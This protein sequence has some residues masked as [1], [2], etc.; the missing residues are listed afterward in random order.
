MRIVTHARD[1]HLNVWKLPSLTETGLEVILPIDIAASGTA[2]EAVRKPWLV[3]SL[4]VNTLNFCGFGE[5]IMPDLEDSGGQ[6][7]GKGDDESEVGAGEGG[8]AQWGQQMLLAVPSAADSE[9]VDI[10]RI[11]DGARMWRSIKPP[12]SITSSIGSASANPERKTGM[13]M[14]LHLQYFRMDEQAEYLL[15]AAGYESGE[16]LIYRH[17]LEKNL[18]GKPV[19]SSGESWEV[20]YA[21]RPHSQPVLSLCAAVDDAVFKVFTSSADSIISRYEYPLSRLNTASNTKSSSSFEPESTLVDTRH[22]GQQSITMRS[23]QKLLATAGWDGRVRV[24]SSKKKMK[25]LAV[26]KWHSVGCYAVT[27]ASVLGMNTG[28]P[29]GVQVREG[30]QSTAT[31]VPIAH[32]LGG[33]NSS[34]ELVRR[35][36]GQ[37][38]QLTE[39]RLSREAQR[40]FREAARHWVAAGDK[41][42]KVSLWDVY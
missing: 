36:S 40:E 37:Q 15:L 24:Y 14:C 26:L 30:A 25:E 39:Q 22:L 16:L 32:D 17:R 42:G 8:F 11:P 29:V 33:G 3:A 10:M 41:D 35:D 28:K 9:A 7:H 1:H 4:L 18:S 19:Q 13:A 12:I 34:T 6:Q 21:A 31:V 5:C 2:A 27:F 38:I 20:I 23:D